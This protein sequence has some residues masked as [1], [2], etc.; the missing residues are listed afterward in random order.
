MNEIFKGKKI[1]ITGAGTIGSALL[2]QILKYDVHTVRIFDN[3]ELKLHDLKQI[4]RENKKVKLLLGDIRDKQR[5][6]IAM[7]DVD[8]V[9]ATAALKHVSFCEENPIDA[10]AT[11]V[12]GTQ[13]LIE[14]CIEENVEYMVN[15]STDKAVSPINVMGATKLVGERLVVSAANYKGKCKTI[16][17]SV[18]FGNVAGSSGSVI[19]IFD[20]QIKN[21]KPLT[22]TDREMT[23]FIIKCDDAINLILETIKLSRGQEIF[24]LNMSSLKIMD[25]ASLMNKNNN[26]IQIIGPIKGEKI[27][28]ELFTKE[29]S[30]I[31]MQKGNLL[32]IPPLESIDYYKEIGFVHIN[33]GAYS[34]EDNLMDIKV[35]REYLD[36]I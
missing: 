32:V 8:I 21:N 29:E 9:F 26:P 12:I 34:S 11:N 35:L 19:Q 22:I 18:R 25:L 6:K 27:H 15:I 20:T 4:Y 7:R 33:K 24:V 36:L 17:S 13:N 5:L 16:F 31:I 14:A 23:R 1:F 28:E 3:C 30:G 2:K 10:I